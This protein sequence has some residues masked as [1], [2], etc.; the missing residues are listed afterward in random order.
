MSW[1]NATNR[2]PHEQGGF[3]LTSM[4][5][6]LNVSLGGPYKTLTGS[7]MKNTWTGPEKATAQISHKHLKRGI[8]INVMAHLLLMAALGGAYLWSGGVLFQ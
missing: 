3:P 8:Y 1:V 5:W 6:A 2:S 4:A 7:A